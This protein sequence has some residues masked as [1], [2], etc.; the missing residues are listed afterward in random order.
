MRT[1][2]LA[3]V[4]WLEGRMLEEEEEEEEEEMMSFSCV[5]RVRS[6]FAS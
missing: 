2:L 3:V 4:V 6:G 1:G 5:G